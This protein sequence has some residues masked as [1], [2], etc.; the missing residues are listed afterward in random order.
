MWS[1]PVFQLLG[2]GAPFEIAALLMSG[3]LVM[4]LQVP[5]EG[6]SPEPVPAAAD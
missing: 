3:V 6:K 5:H 1:T 4:A 2:R